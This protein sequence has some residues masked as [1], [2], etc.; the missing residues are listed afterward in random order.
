MAPCRRQQRLDMGRSP[1]KPLAHWL[2]RP[3]ADPGGHPIKG[4]GINSIPVRFALISAAL[5]ALG[6]GAHQA[7]FDH[8]AAD[9]GTAGLLLFAAM[10]LGKSMSVPT[11]AA[12]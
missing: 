3:D 5:A 6:V 8:S 7:A 10:M 11:V 4:K 12:R 1:L 2:R 9:M